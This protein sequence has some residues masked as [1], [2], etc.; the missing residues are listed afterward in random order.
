MVFKVFNNEMNFMLCFGIQINPTAVQ[1]QKMFAA[2][3]VFNMSGVYLRNSRLNG[4]RNAII[5]II[6]LVF[7]STTITLFSNQSNTSPSI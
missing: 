1:V 6:V 4:K 7:F 5:M 3:S 2:N